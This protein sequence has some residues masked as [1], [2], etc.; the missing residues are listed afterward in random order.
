MVKF[1]FERFFG[2]GEIMRKI[3][4]VDFDG[5]LSHNSLFEEMRPNIPLFSKLIKAKNN[6]HMLILWTC[7]GDK[8]LKEAVEF[9]EENGLFFDAINKNIPGFNYVNLSCK[10]V[11]DLYVDDKAPGSIDYFMGMKI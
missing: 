4:A 10:V 7:R 2:R 11:A 3:I 9:C 6:G 5:T 1:L 8:Y